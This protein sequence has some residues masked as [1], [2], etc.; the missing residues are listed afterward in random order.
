MLLSDSQDSMGNTEI[1]SRGALQLTSA[2]TGISHSEKAHG[3]NEAY[4]CQIWASPRSGQDRGKPAY[5]TRCVCVPISD[6][7]PR[8]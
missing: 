3:G 6:R 7:F 1:L 2:G 8:S 5:F 4:F